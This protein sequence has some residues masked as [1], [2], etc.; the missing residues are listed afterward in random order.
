MRYFF[1]AIL[2]LFSGFSTWVTLETSYIQAFPP[3]D[4]WNTLQIFCDLVISASLVI[5][6]VFRRRLDEDRPL[7][8]V[9]LLALG[10]ALAGSIALLVY[11]VIDPYAT[12]REV[13]EQPAT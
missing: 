5:W 8:P 2:I 6:M 1:I 9:A 10:A 12:N 4:D 11:F 3:F 13:E 7:W